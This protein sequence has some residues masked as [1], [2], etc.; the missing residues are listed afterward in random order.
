MQAGATAEFTEGHGLALVFI[1][2]ESNEGRILGSRIERSDEIF[3]FQ[4][5]PL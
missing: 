3:E 5:R 4:H 1:H 2:P